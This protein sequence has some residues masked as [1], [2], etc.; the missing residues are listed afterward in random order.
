MSE[1]AG[2][3]QGGAAQVKADPQSPIG[4]GEERRNI[5]RWQGLI[6]GAG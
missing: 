5:D 6:C 3:E 2:S 1:M 4:S